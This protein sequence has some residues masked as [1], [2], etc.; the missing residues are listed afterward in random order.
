MALKIV[1]PPDD[2]PV[3]VEE[4][5]AH[6]RVDF[7]DDDRLI[8]SYIAAA[9]AAL[10]GP[11]GWLGRALRPQTWD[12]YCDE[13][14]CAGQTLELPLGPL[15]SVDGVFYRASDGSETEIDVAN[16]SADLAPMP[17]RV[18]PVYG[19][20]WPF[21]VIATNA[22]RVRFTAGYVDA[23][24]SDPATSTVPEPIKV[25]IMMMV[26]DYYDPQAPAATDSQPQISVTPAVKALLAPYKML[27]YA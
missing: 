19:F 10:D 7:E 23:N 1:T 9:T 15:L 20:S 12:F 22:V 16:Y 5:Q 6:L 11:N 26:A 25:A 2:F 24:E 13:F 17:G 18:V 4:V 27:V 3:T 14:P 21:P 8:E